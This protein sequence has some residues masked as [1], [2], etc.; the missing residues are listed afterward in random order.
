MDLQHSVQNEQLPGL[1]PSP[2]H[3][4]T[5]SSTCLVSKTSVFRGCVL[6]SDWPVVFFSRGNSAEVSSSFLTNCLT[7]LSKVHVQMTFVSKTAQG[8][9]D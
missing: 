1:G 5:H 9:A 7:I 8:P 2:P 3:K 6:S 4:K